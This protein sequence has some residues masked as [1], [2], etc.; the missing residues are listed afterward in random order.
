MIDP[1]VFEV[2]GIIVA[3]IGSNA[4]LYLGL[5]DKIDKL[6]ANVGE[7]E[8][9]I[10]SIEEH[11]ADQSKFCDERHRNLEERLRQIGGKRSSG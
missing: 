5:G 8:T 10:A 3:V 11:N 7:N 9:R 6:R 4:M 2:G 1:A